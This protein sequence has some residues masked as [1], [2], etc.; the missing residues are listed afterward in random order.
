MT[1]PLPTAG[2]KY[3]RASLQQIINAVRELQILLS[4]RA[5]IPMKDVDDG[6]NKILQV[7]AGVVEAVDP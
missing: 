2:E 3:E 4:P 6:K 5:G 7:N 1:L